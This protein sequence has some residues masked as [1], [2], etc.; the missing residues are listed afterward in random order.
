MP[1]AAPQTSD[2]IHQ[3]TAKSVAGNL[4]SVGLPVGTQDVIPVSADSPIPKTPELH[5]VGAEIV[6]EDL[7]HML[8]STVS[9]LV[10]GTEN[11]RTTKS[12][13]FLQKLK[14]RLLRKKGV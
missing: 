13:G 4:Q 14:E 9:D 2:Q 12:G 1:M 11:Y 10:G 3:A 7:S 5:E 8:G 6:G